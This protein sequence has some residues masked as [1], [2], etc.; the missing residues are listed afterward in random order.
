[1]AIDWTW[2][3]VGTLAQLA[4]VHPDPSI[5]WTWVKNNSTNADVDTLAN[6]MINGWD[7][8][9]ETHVETARRHADA[10]QELQG[11]YPSVTVHQ[12]ITSED[13]EESL[14]VTFQS[15]VA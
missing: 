10:V 13:R 1:M 6:K 15:G 5:F 11:I 14:D 3:E 2:A 8:S 7:N 4:A 9:G 12:V